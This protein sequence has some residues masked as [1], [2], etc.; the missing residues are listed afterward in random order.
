M[1]ASVTSFEQK[2]DV[3][4]RRI[5]R[6]VLAFMLVLLC[7]GLGG[8]AF[9]QSADEQLFKAVE[10]NDADGVKSA[11]EAGA[12]LGAKNDKGMTAADLA[13]DLGHFRIAHTLLAYRNNGSQ[14][15]PRVTENA[16]KALAAPTART[17]APRPATSTAPPP[18]EPKLADITPPM[19]P[20]S[21]PTPAGR[22]VEPPSIELPPV[23]SPAATQP[24]RDLARP[25][26]MPAVPRTEQEV[27]EKPMVKPSPGSPQRDVSAEED[28]YGDFLNAII[29]G[30][31]S[32]VTL[33]GLIGG[34]EEKAPPQEEPSVSGDRKLLN[35]A[36]RFSGKPQ[37]QPQS[38]SSA[39]R[40]VD[41]LRDAVGGQEQAENAFGLPETSPVPPLEPPVTSPP[42]QEDVEPPGIVPPVESAE[43]P[44]N[45]DLPPLAAPEL[46]VPG[47]NT[48]TEIDI[49]GIG[50]TPAAP[51]PSGRSAQR[52]AE[53]MPGL[54]PSE[55]PDTGTPGISVPGLPPGLE[56][57]GLPGSEQ[58]AP[59]SA[60]NEIPGII[61]P[62]SS[63]A[64]QIPELP[65][66]LEALPGSQTGQLRR[67]GGLEEPPDTTT[68]PPPGGDAA[69][70][71]RRYDEILNRTPR[72]TEGRFSSTLSEYQRG[73]QG[74]APSR[75][76]QTPVTPTP[77]QPQPGPQSQNMP[78]PEIPGIIPPPRASAQDDIRDPEQI[79]KSAHESARLRAEQDIKQRRSDQ[80]A[81]TENLL[82]SDASA[83]ALK[84]SSQVVTK[85]EQPS[86]RLMDRLSNLTKT[87]YQ[88]EDIYGLP[89]DQPSTATE[90][91]QPKKNIDVAE[92]PDSKQAKVDDRLQKL[93]RYFRGNQE[94]EAGI[95]PPAS[96]SREPL[97]Q[98]IDNLV[99]ENDPAR[100]RVVDD[101]MLDLSGVE[102]D[103]EY[104]R[105]QP[106]ATATKDGQLN[107]NFLD[108]LNNVL[109]PAQRQR[110]AVSD[111]PPPEP[112]RLGLGEL[113]VP[114]DQIREKA[115]PKIPDPWTMTIQRS[116]A[117]GGS[118][119]LGVTAISPEDGS[120]L[121]T[122]KGVVSQMVGRIRELL[123]G[124]EQKSGAPSVESLDEADRQSAAEKLLS[125]ALRDGAP[126]ALPDQN[127]WP[128]TEVDAS[129]TP[130]GVPPAPRSGTLTRTSLSDVVLSL[131]ESVTLENTLP[132]QQDGIDPLN[133]CIKKN[134]GTTLFCVE[135]V[136]W[137]A[138]LQA[139]FVV[140][141]I[142]YTGPMA[143]T[144]YDQGTPSRFHTLFDSA[145]FEDVVAYYQSRYG[146][147]T[148][149]WKRSIAPLAK[150][151][152]DNPTV[153][154][155][156]RDSKSNV[157]SVLEVRKFDDSRGGFPDMSRGA[158]MLYH[159]NAPSIF[160]QVSSHELMRLRRTR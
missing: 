6:A 89:I 79:L 37:P 64:D 114:S 138:D 87:P 149:I 33:G 85:R 88:N 132:P 67:P 141:T 136:D 57:P 96:V 103:P 44:G 23:D 127:Q 119:T 53:P 76:P 131:G 122:E 8:Q 14:T 146:E 20:K 21:I 28:G 25:P 46:G 70:R 93:A 29:G 50:A 104:L 160:P 36:D 41:R 157:I 11:I 115:K 1:Q 47:N 133:E 2:P 142:L 81:S 68:L 95:L 101:R 18:P 137:P 107:P 62:S 42:M 123:S 118:R 105:G 126:A 153:A 56:I 112:G 27:A 97:P 34:S 109:G 90:D 32:V 145:D 86:S 58:G 120:E 38:E 22:P 98:V 15:K 84:P 143:I 40:M 43:A 31:K 74:Q 100:G 12:D 117:E 45:T 49:P 59:Q 80:Q 10:L 152:T 4:V 39:G 77:V 72:E 26:D 129:N 78:A 63:S 121:R 52:S 125:D 116:D 69:A 92:L 35:P 16:R 135:P 158:V 13:V 75:A 5:R 113:D 73:T 111:V 91:V 106:G 147:P 155:R 17:P 139:A 71:M 51:M 150:P 124:P 128:V 60:G 156:S 102:R 134:R 151:R 61:P 7:L 65:P 9:A 24:A 66:G 110:P 148:E 30:V 55:I 154:W 3:K 144:R 99:P 19:K 130:P 83:H 140:P 94:E 54:V 48:G 108:K 159:L 82:P